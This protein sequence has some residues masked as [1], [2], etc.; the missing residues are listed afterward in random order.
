MAGGRRWMLVRIAGP[1]LFFLVAAVSPAAEPGEHVVLTNL[2]SLPQGGFKVEAVGPAGR[3]YSLQLTFDLKSWRTMD[4]VHGNA[5]GISF[6][7]L[8]GSRGVTRFYR[9]RADEAKTATWLTNYHGWTNSIVLSNATV[10]ALVVPAVG[11]IMQFRFHHQPDGPFW[12]NTGL[13]GKAPAANSWDTAG[14]FGGDK[15]WPAPQSVWNWPPPRAFDSLSFTGAVTETGVV[16]LAGPVDASFGMRVLRQIS[17]HPVEP[18]LRVASAFEKVAGNPRQVSVWVV[19]QLKDP[20][21]VFMPI[22]AGTLFTNGYTRL[23]TV[24]RDLVITNNLVSL[25]R[26]PG[27]GTK[28]GNDASALLWIG[29]ENA[30]LIES[31]RVPGLAKAAY[32]DGGSSAEV[33]TNPNPTAYVELEFLGPLERLA[34]GEMAERVSVYTLLPRAQAS[35]QAEAARILAE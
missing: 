29:P 6:Q 24:P 7:V 10:Q 33:Y 17:L 4:F 18:I 5:Q 27:T 13:W 11:R 9:V 15:V 32:P 3:V 30:L 21:R 14:S 31:P 26:D 2:A 19:T 1:L 22:P 23:G 8:P 34:V 25:A 12:E 20:E 16:T 28:I 35:A